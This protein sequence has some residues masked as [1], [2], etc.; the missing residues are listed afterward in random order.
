MLF[1]TEHTCVKKKRHSDESES[2]RVAGMRTNAHLRPCRRTF[3][4]RRELEH[5]R[6]NCIRRLF[7]LFTLAFN[8][9][10]TAGETWR[11]RPRKRILLR[12]LGHGCVGTR[13]SRRRLEI[14][15]C[16]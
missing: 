15:G 13:R 2:Q 14:R 9:T 12:A 8:I 1:E 4:V 5:L 6:F 10:F 16:G 11:L 7:V 3:A